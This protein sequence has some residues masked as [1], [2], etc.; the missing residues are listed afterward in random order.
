MM[1]YLDSP[2]QKQTVRGNSGLTDYF[3]ANQLSRPDQE[4]GTAKVDQTLCRRCLAGNEG[5]DPY[6]T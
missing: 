5:M 2:G 6:S 1:R 3:K 4:Q